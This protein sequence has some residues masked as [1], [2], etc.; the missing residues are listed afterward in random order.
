[1]HR[2]DLV[3]IRFLPVVR[4]TVNIDGTSQMISGPTVGFINGDFFLVSIANSHS[5]NI[6]LTGKLTRSTPNIVSRILGDAS[7]N[8]SLE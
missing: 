5:G 7:K 6:L 3:F 8:S 2:P 4:I 1:M